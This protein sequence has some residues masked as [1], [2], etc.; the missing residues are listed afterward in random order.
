MIM[1]SGE[2]DWMVLTTRSL[3]PGTPESVV[4]LIRNSRSN[5]GSVISRVPKRVPSVGSVE[6]F[7]LE[8]RTSNA[9]P[10][11]TLISGAKAKPSTLN[12]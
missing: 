9:S 12:V 7:P 4:L 3:V 5:G 2:D 10:P 6:E 1:N 8:M 11:S